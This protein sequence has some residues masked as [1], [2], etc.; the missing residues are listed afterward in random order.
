MR[1]TLISEAINFPKILDMDCDD[2]KEF[3]KSKFDNKENEL[4][5]LY[6]LCLYVSNEELKYYDPKEAEKRTKE[7]M[8]KAW[9]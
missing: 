4:M 6:S 5:S 7:T 8:E 3:I 1:E 9:E 2:T